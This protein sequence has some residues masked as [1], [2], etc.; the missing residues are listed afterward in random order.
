MQ[1]FDIRKLVLYEVF[2]WFV[3]G[4][5]PFRKGGRWQPL[6]VQFHKTLRPGP[7]WFLP[8][9]NFWFLAKW[10]FFS[11]L[12]PILQ[13]RLI[14]CICPVV[15]QKNISSKKS[16]LFPLEGGLSRNTHGRP[17]HWLRLFYSKQTFLGMFSS[18][19][20]GYPA[21]KWYAMKYN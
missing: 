9:S 12:F 8:A 5:F 13:H 4:F 14:V 6:F 7:Q 18:N 10:F 19:G 16:P 1:H 15:W 3:W 17:F 2:C 11:H 21:M 20:K